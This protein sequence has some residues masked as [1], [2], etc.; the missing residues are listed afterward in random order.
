M[1][2]KTPLQKLSATVS[3]PLTATPSIVLSRSPLRPCCRARMNSSTLRWLN[4]SSKR[5]SRRTRLKNFVRDVVDLTWEVLRARRL[6]TGV[7]TVR[8]VAGFGWC[9]MQSGTAH[10]LLLATIES[11]GNVGLLETNPREERSTGHSGRRGSRSMK[12]RL[13][14]RR[15]RLT[16]SNGSTGCWRARR[17]DETTPFVKLID[18]EK[19][20][21]ARRGVQSKRSKTPNSEKSRV[22]IKTSED[23]DLRSTPR[24]QC[25]QRNGE[26]GSEKQG[27]QGPLVEERVAPRLECFDLGRRRS[28][29]SRQRP[30]SENSGTQVRYR[31]VSPGAG[32]CRGP[33]YSRPGASPTHEPIAGTNAPI[34]VRHQKATA[35]D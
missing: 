20:S 33:N 22:E 11:L 28:H 26:H 17:L 4:V 6:K 29:K 21:A 23:L 5:R 14:P 35:A 15:K 10:L 7:L 16:L 3:R 2:K 30:G 9:R 24:S 34:P 18:I 1:Q 25:R 13:K 31:E 27:G 19:R 12:S 32:D 8:S